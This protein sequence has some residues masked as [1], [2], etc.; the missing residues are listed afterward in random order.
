MWQSISIGEKYLKTS[1]EG[2]LTETVVT[3]SRFIQWAKRAVARG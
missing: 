1:M 2:E 3:Q